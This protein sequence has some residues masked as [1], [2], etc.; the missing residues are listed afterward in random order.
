MRCL[1]ESAGEPARHG[2]PA[3]SKRPLI[4]PRRAAELSGLFKMLANDTRLR[5]LHALV[6][7]G[8]LC[9]TDLAAEVGMAP[10]AVS[11]HLQ[12]LA[13]RRVVAARRDGVRLFYHL[14]DPC[15]A[16]LLD[17]GLCLLE[18]T[19]GTSTPGREARRSARRTARR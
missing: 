4:E 15:I 10:Q 1:P 9:V 14:A 3:P 11:N 12:R 6:R 13:D 5:L 7:A 18:E 17:L 19:G 8:E 2:K 16:G